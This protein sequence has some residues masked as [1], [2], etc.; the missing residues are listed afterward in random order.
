[1]DEKNTGLCVSKS[2]H[3]FGLGR[4]LVAELWDSCA[5][6]SPHYGQL[7]VQT[8]VDRHLVH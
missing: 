5:R 1:M 6:L 2:A 8:L 7:V 3:M 4:L